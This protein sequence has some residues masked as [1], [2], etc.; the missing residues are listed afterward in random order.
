M[1]MS[2]VFS[3]ALPR[4]DIA[5]AHIW[6]LEAALIPITNARL[7]FS[8]NMEAPSLILTRD[9]SDTSLVTERLTFSC[10]LG[11]LVFAPVFKFLSLFTRLGS[12]WLE[13]HSVKIFSPVTIC[14]FHCTW[15]R[16]Q[17]IL[18]KAYK[19]LKKKLYKI[20]CCSATTRCFEHP[21]VP[22][23][24]LFLFTVLKF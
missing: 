23:I 19:H 17:I 13:E 15:L 9:F 7:F 3:P 4:L 1:N 22:T 14:H 10:L 18:S 12:S 5:A 16:P 2:D 6:R 11:L 20:T 8:K 21:S 24:L